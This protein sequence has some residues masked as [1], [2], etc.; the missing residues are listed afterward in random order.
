MAAALTSAQKVHAVYDYLAATCEYDWDFEWPRAYDAYGVLIDGLSAC[1]GYSQAFKLFMDKLGIPCY[2]VY[3][4]AWNGFKNVSHAWNMVQVDGIRYHVDPSG[5]DLFDPALRDAPGEVGHRPCGQNHQSM[6][7]SD[8]A[9]GEGRSWLD[10]DMPYAAPY[11]Y[12]DY[13]DPIEGVDT[14]SFADTPPTTW[15]VK[16]GYIDYV[17]DAGIM[18][19]YQGTPFFGPDDLLT[20]APGSTGREAAFWTCRLACITPRRSK[21][22][23]NT[24]SPRAMTTPAAS[25]PRTTSRASSWRP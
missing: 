6:L 20:R 18:N 13:W 11:T 16:G 17:K 2:V 22:A 12:V 3:G 8:E 25:A 19:G 14:W 4:V 21:G 7:V 24:A 1:Q 9:I 23:S 10:G 5:G 15:Y